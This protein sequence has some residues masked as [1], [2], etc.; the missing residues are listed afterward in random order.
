MFKRRPKVLTPAQMEEIRTKDFFD[1]ILPSTIKFLTD[2]YIMGIPTGAYG[3]FGSTRP[4]RRNRRFWHSLRI[5]VVSHS[6][7]I[8]GWWK[9]TS[10]GKSCRTPPAA[11]S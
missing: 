2:H 9:Q 3:S 5:A 6:A 11:T 4:L 7:F 1:C 10:S 8:T